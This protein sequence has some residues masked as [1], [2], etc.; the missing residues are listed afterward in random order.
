M[1]VWCGENRR[2]RYN[3]P[4]GLITGGDAGSRLGDSTPAWTRG[5]PR[6]VDMSKTANRPKRDRTKNRATTTD[7]QPPAAPFGVHH[8]QTLWAA[9][10][11]SESPDNPGFFDGSYPQWLKLLNDDILAWAHTEA[12]S[13]EC[14]GF[15][16]NRRD[17][18]QGLAESL[19]YLRRTFLAA[20]LQAFQQ[21]D[22]VTDE[23][24]RAIH[25]AHILLDELQSDFST[26]A[27]H[28]LA[29][30]GD[31]QSAAIAAA[32]HQRIRSVAQAFNLPTPQAQHTPLDKEDRLILA[33]L[34]Q[35]PSKL[36]TLDDLARVDRHT[37]VAHTNYLE[38]QGLIC[39]P[40]GPRKGMQITAS[41]RQTLSQAGHP[42]SP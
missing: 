9:A 21:P 5:R 22:R 28:N 16:A 23:Q 14:Y 10:V 11:G 38:Q 24:L 1:A 34:A 8:W 33:Q 30:A 39:R 15:T 29:A 13:I 40:K 18:A 4:A 3:C 42:D 25:H 6:G 37:A 7:P 2:L 20:Y 27:Q 36:H 19:Q 12:R 17:A 35:H 41:G 31:S 26:L 32:L